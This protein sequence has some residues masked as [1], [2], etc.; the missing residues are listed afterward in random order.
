MGAAGSGPSGVAEGGAGSGISGYFQKRTLLAKGSKVLVRWSQR[1]H[2]VCARGLARR[3]Y[4]GTCS[5]GNF[6]DSP[7]HCRCMGPLVSMPMYLDCTCAKLGR[8]GLPWSPR[9]AA[10][11][12]V[13]RLPVAPPLVEPS[14]AQEVAEGAHHTQVMRAAF[15]LIIALGITAGLPPVDQEASVIGE[16]CRPGFPTHRFGGTGA[17]R[18]QPAAR[19]PAQFLP[20]P[21]CKRSAGQPSRPDTLSFDAW[22]CVPQMHGHEQHADATRDDVQERVAIPQVGIHGAV[23]AHA[24][25]ARPSLGDHMIACVPVR[26][27]CHHLSSVWVS[28][29]V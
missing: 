27:P 25:T 9:V 11:R 16:V 22:S 14:E 13:A 10:W 18:A 23:W 1:L 4:F 7:R 26:R 20:A 17:V 5:R 24:R 2:Q 29:V 12:P 28:C 21:C 3:I 8:S 6:R 15:V 19:S